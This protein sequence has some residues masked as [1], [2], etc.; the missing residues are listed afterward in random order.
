MQSAL[1]QQEEP[2]GIASR[3]LTLVHI[4]SM[5]AALTL[6]RGSAYESTWLVCRRSRRSAATPEAFPPI[7]G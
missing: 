5:L 1:V 6:K 2:F 3:E 7:S 4:G